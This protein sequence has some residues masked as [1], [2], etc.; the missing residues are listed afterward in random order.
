MN[1]FLFSSFLPSIHSCMHACICSFIHLTY[2]PSFLPPKHSSF[3]PSTHPSTHP[4]IQCIK[5]L[6][7][8]RPCFGGKD[9]EIHEAGP[10]PLGVNESP[11]RTAICA[12]REMV[13]S[14]CFVHHGAITSS[15]LPGR[16]PGVWQVI[17]PFQWRHLK[18]R[19]HVT[20]L[21]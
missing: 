12:G 7:C 4:S 13:T 14:I 11:A 18:G 21:S 6:G 16:K 1:L 2:Y 20:S 10:C 15:Q 5:Q 8:V 9:A 17:P 19:N 3:H